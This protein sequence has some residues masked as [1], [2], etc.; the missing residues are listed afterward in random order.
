MELESLRVPDLELYERARAAYF[1]LLGAQD[2]ARRD[3]VGQL[4]ARREQDLVAQEARV[5]S[6]EL[7]RQYGALLDEYPILLQFLALQQGDE[8]GALLREIPPATGV[9]AAPVTP[10]P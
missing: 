2:N 5:A 8:L 3:A 6:F 10:S 4:A 7:L 1:D 9:A